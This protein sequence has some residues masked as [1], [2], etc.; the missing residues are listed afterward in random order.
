MIWRKAQETPANVARMATYIRRLASVGIGG[1]GLVGGKNAALGEMEGALREAGVPTPDGFA[2]TADAYRDA[3][4]EAGAWPR[5]RA[6]LSGLDIAD[7]AELARRGA[8]ARKIVYACNRFLLPALP[9]LTRSRRR[10]QKPSAPAARPPGS[11]PS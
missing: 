2:I 7:V 3:L 9:R 6:L 8:E 1:V 4:T 5:L 10:S 11:R